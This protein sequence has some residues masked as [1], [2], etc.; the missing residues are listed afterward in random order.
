MKIKCDTKKFQESIAAADY[1]EKFDE[2]LGKRNYE[3]MPIISVELFESKTSTQLNTI[4][5]DF[6]IIANLLYTDTDTIYAESMRHEDLRE[7]FIKETEYGVQTKRKKS[8]R[9]RT[10]SQFSKS[11]CMEFIPLYREVWHG[12][13]ND[14]YAEY[15]IIHWS[16]EENINKPDF[17]RIEVA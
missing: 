7:F 1:R 5:R 2:W 11:D 3:N 10:L 13:I 17:E 8:I 16:K 6:G 9:L 4:W 14:Q 12:I 15:V